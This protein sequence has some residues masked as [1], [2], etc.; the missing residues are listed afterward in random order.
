[1]CRIDTGPRRSELSWIA[2][3]VVHLLAQVRSVAARTRSLATAD[4]L[5]SSFSIGA[6]SASAGL[7]G[8][9]TSRVRQLMSL[10]ARGT[11]LVAVHAA[12]I[13]AASRPAK[14][15]RLGGEPSLYLPAATLPDA[16][17]K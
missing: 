4:G 16:P 13:P 12:A 5:S 2:R 17:L 11:R 3:P 6:S 14:A 1:M 15:A 7:S 9:L 8:S 10:G